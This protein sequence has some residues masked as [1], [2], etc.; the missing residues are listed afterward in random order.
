MLSGSTGLKFEPSPTA[1]GGD[2][3][4]KFS[5]TPGE[6]TCMKNSAGRDGEYAM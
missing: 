3:V 6:D 1:G 5:S 4:P 2:A